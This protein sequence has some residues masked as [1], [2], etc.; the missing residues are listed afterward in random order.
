MSYNGHTKQSLIDFEADIA[1][2]YE[3]GK[4]KAPV[5]LRDGNEQELID[6]F[7]LLNVG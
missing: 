3:S 1:S 4:I 5:H 6:L 7:S 2:I